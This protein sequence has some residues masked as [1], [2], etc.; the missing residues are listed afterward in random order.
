MLPTSH[1]IIEV[2]SPPEVAPLRAF[3]LAPFSIPG[4]HAQLYSLEPPSP[5]QAAISPDLGLFAHL[6]GSSVLLFALSLPPNDHRADTVDIVPPS[7]GC[8]AKIDLERRQEKRSG[9]GVA[10]DQGNGSRL[11]QDGKRTPA[12]QPSLARGLSWSQCTSLGASSTAKQCFGR[13]FTAEAPGA[14]GMDFEEGYG[15]FV[16]D[17]EGH[18]EGEYT[19]ATKNFEDDPTFY[20]EVTDGQRAQ[21]VGETSEGVSG[22]LAVACGSEV[23]LWRVSR[24]LRDRGKRNGEEDGR[25]LGEDGVS[26]HASG[27]RY[28]TAEVL[29]EWNSTVDTTDAATED[30]YVSPDNVNNAGVISTLDHNES[31]SSISPSIDN[32]ATISASAG[33]EENT[34]NRIKAALAPEQDLMLDGPI[35]ERIRHDRACVLGDMRYLSFRPPCPRTS[36]MES[37]APLAAWRNGGVAILG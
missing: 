22:H 15:G 16:G 25:Y 31:S 4:T 30:T 2:I 11:G 29:T 21:G 6:D 35:A 9:D 23:R 12:R 32:P 36:N 7:S 1:A 17:K 13:V 33:W 20:A 8:V 24:L 14:S 3:T 18:G 28:T 19:R 10:R 5:S 37:P 34:R 27:F 26:R